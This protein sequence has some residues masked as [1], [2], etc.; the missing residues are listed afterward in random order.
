MAPHDQI[1]ALRR[2]PEVSTRVGVRPDFA[3]PLAMTAVS[4]VGPAA[5][6][7][8]LYFVNWW[9]D[10]ALVGGL[11]I[12]AWLV[13]GAF[14]GADSKPI[15]VLSLILALL[16]NCPHFSATLYRLYQSPE[17]IRQFPV[18]ACGLPFVMLG[19]VFA[20]FWLPQ[21]VAPYFL[22][23]YV[24]WSPY[25][26]SGQT[27]GLTMIYARRSGFRIGRRERLALS[28]FVFSAFVY[29]VIHIQANGFSDLFGMTVPLPLL[30][31]WYDAATQAVMATAALVFVGLAVAWCRRQRRVLPPIVLL[32]ALAH[33]VWFVPGTAV[34]AFFV[35]IPLFHSLQYLLVA[36][37]VQLNRR[38][39]VTGV[40]RSWRRVRAE[41]LHWG[42]RNLAGG[43]LLFIGIPVLFAWVPLPFATIAGIVAAAINIHHFFVDGVIWKLRDDANASALTMNVAELCRP[44]AIA[45]SVGAPRPA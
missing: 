19:A 2:G 1:T 33:F 18:T 31:R 22:M 8:P 11:S 40:E 15:L 32:P 34:K 13:I 12:A 27:V 36:G 17:H 26:Y 28:A 35:I 10:A 7:L 20:C 24:L 29:G 41:A 39:G 3:G 42:A 16:V 37:V 25:H 6:A 14:A 43:V 5:T 4:R 21:T 23:L 9:V 44:R 30:P 45:P 38:I